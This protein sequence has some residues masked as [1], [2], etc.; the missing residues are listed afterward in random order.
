MKKM[1]LALFCAMFF[2]QLVFGGA[3]QVSSTNLDPAPAIPGQ[4]LDLWV[5]LTNN[6]RDPANNAF[7]NLKLAQY[8]Y[9]TD[10]PFSL[11][12][13]DS[14]MREL[15]TI[16][17]NQTVV[18]KYSILVDSSALEGV[19]T[20][21]IEAGESGN[22]KN[23]TQ[24]SITIL[25]RK[26]DIK[27]ISSSP[28]TAKI[29]K[30]FSLAIEI[31]NTGSSNAFD[32][33]LGASE[34]RTVTSTGVVVERSIIPLGAAFSY[35]PQLN[36]GE[37]ATV[38]LNF[39]V[40]PGADASG[41]YIPITITFQDSNKTEFSETGYIGLKVEDA[42]EL[43]ATVAEAKPLLSPGTMAALTID[44]YNIGAGTAHDLLVSADVN[45]MSLQKSEFYIGSLDSDNFDSV[46]LNGT[47]KSSLQSGMQN[48]NLTL[49]YKNAFGETTTVEK[50]VPVRI[51]SAEEAAIESG[52]TGSP[53]LLIVIVIVIIIAAYWLLRRRG[54][55]QK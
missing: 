34:E 30:T 11:A 3:M 26:P 49:V 29:G 28:D 33:S 8:G 23:A 38:N 51:Y 9:Q 1:F 47:V 31:K 14:A 15:G 39:V 50:A 35:L 32:V 42:P 40:D 7:V 45:F 16:N 37:T 36:A 53:V 25:N 18:V 27:I 21:T 52:A 12:P 19:Y 2:A 48:V 44:I 22:P 54:K 43:G 41:H 13:D 17:P 20:V 4:Y 5:H 55:K 46:T 24:V 6:S 10:F